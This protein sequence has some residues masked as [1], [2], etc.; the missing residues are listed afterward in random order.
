MKRR[1]LLVRLALGQA[2][3]VKL[4]SSVIRPRLS[5][6]AVRL[7]GDWLGTAGAT[8]VTT[9]AGGGAGAGVATGIAGSG[10]AF[11][12]AGG[13]GFATRGATVRARAKGSACAVTCCQSARS[14]SER[15]FFAMAEILAMRD[16]EATAAAP[17]RRQVRGP[18]APTPPSIADDAVDVEPPWAV[19]AETDLLLDV[20]GARRA[21]DQVHVRGMKP[22]W[23]AEAGPGRLL[24]AD[25]LVR[26]QHHDVGLGHEVERGRLSAR[27]PSSACRSPRCRTAR[28]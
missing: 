17:R 12:R 14:S 11:G 16:A 25:H 6:V 2:M 10:G 26:G 15:R 24:D 21:G 22:P 19:G 13:A 7:S 4:A 8:T 27:T 5:L 28:R 1:E 9:G 18:W 3:Q 20:A 23:G